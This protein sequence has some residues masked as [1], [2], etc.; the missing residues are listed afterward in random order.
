MYGLVRYKQGNL[1]MQKTINY[2]NNRY[3]F[4][5]PRWLPDLKVAQQTIPV[6]ICWGDQEDVAPAYVAQYL[7][8]EVCPKAKLTWIK[9]AGHFLE[10][11]N[12]K[13]F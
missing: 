7:K 12:P 6:H 4:E 10:Q 1:V 5:G 11:E 3:T 9:G 13:I 2:Y 8:D